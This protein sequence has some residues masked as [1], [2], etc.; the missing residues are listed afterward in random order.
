LIYGHTRIPVP[1][2]LQA[3]EDAILHACERKVNVWQ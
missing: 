2:R 3:R 1:R